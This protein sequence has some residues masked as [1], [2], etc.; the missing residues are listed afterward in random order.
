MEYNKVEKTQKKKKTEV[1]LR[2]LLGL[3]GMTKLLDND[4]IPEKQMVLE[5]A[6]KRKDVPTP[7]DPVMHFNLPTFEESF[8]T[9]VE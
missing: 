5:E 7:P 2:R 3:I 4:C 9:Y 8:K 1:E 6:L